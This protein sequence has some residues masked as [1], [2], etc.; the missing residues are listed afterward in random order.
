MKKI[1]EKVVLVALIC[2]TF[3]FALTTALYITNVIPQEKVEN[4][5]VAIILLSVL[6]IMYVG[7]AIYL[8]YVNFSERVNV[9][10]I[11]LYHNADSATSASSKVVNNIVKG[12]A[13][14][15]SKVKVRKTTL[16]VDDKQGVIA[17]VHVVVAAECVTESIPY[18]H[19]LLMHNFEETLGVKFSAINF[20]IDKFVNKFVPNSTTA[21]AE[22]N[23]KTSETVDTPSADETVAADTDT[24]KTSQDEEEQIVTMEA[25]PVESPLSELFKTLEE[26]ET[27]TE[28][29][30]PDTANNKTDEEK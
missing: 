20:V 11:L 22:T 30:E 17:T 9:K 2:I 27:T 25:T 13:K 7:L 26:L 14:K 10:Q 18:L 12:C 21:S 8:V 16:R 24:A 5:S 19:Q 28:K 1:V 6:A 23:D 29:K 15:V 4:N 3:V